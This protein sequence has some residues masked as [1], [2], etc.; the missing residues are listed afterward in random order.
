MNIEELSSSG[1]LRIALVGLWGAA[2]LVALVGLWVYKLRAGDGGEVR[3]RWPAASTLAAGADRPTLV[4]FAHPRC[5]CTR[6]SLGELRGLLS[7]FA[8]RMTTHVV[9]MRPAGSS[10]SWSH[11]DTWAT[12]SA[13]VG[14]RVATDIDGREAKLFGAATSGH[15]VL[16]DAQGRL[17]Y[18]GGITPARGH[19]GSSPQLDRLSRLLERETAGA[20]D[21]SAAPAPLGR[22]GPVFGCALREDPR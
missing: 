11:T 7:R 6:A 18:G 9:F 19:Q 14:V 22:P 10:A 2:L 21:V 3:E 16:Y 4:M 15:V 12:A 17:L 8:G 13:L 20:A 5:P 1:R